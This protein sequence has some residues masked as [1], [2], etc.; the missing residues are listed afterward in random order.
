MKFWYNFIF[1]YWTRM[2]HPRMALPITNYWTR[3][4]WVLKKLLVYESYDQMLLSQEFSLLIQTPVERIPNP[5][6][7]DYFDLLASPY[8]EVIPRHRHLLNL[9]QRW[10]YSITGPHFVV[11]ILGIVQTF[12]FPYKSGTNDLI[13]MNIIRTSRNY[14]HWIYF[15][16][17]I[18]L[19]SP[20]VKWSGL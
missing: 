6:D 18:Q 4:N 10:L 5:E 9:I 12:Q 20:T 2:Y 13:E 15:R 11:P 3:K 19:L 17:E 7:Q 16:I 8:L 14:F 1:S